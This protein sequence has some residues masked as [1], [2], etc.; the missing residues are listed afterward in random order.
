VQQF[1]AHIVDITLGVLIVLAI[2]LAWP[3]CDLQPAPGLQRN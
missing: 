1:Y 2:D 3:W